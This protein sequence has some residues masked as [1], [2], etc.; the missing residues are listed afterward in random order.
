MEQ[1]DAHFLEI[2]NKVIEENIVKS[3]FEI[4][5]IANQLGMSRSAFF[6]RLKA[7]TNTSPSEYVKDYKLARAVEY[8]KNSDLSITDVAYRSG[9]SEVGYFGKCFRKKYGMSPRDFKKQ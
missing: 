2:V 6:K 3:D 8:L 4:D 1:E 9:F 7:L 5:V